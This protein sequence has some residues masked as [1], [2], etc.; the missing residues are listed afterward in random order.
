M[1]TLLNYVTLYPMKFWVWDM[2][3]VMMSTK[4]RN[5]YFI[6]GNF[7]NAVGIFVRGEKSL[8]LSIFESE[9]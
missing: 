8:L 2:A 1:Q 9:T 6:G 7:K 3:K 4:V 5:N